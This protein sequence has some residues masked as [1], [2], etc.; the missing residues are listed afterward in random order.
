MAGWIKEWAS[1]GTN[2]KVVSDTVVGLASGTDGVLEGII[3]ISG[4][5]TIACGYKLDGSKARAG[6][7][8]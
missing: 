4:T 6:G 7:W 8:G 5:G 2:I 1:A 3:L